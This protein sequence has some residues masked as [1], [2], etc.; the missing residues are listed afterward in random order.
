M[1]LVEEYTCI[2]KETDVEF[3][4]SYR[5]IKKDYN[6]VPAYGIEIERKDYIDLKN[7]GLERERIE[8]ISPQRHKVK[9]LLMKLY[10]NQVSP[11]H[12]MDVIG[13]YV[14]E[15]VYEFDSDLQRQ[16]IN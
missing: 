5:L 13:S 3:R 16:A 2:N 15:Y 12:L 8:I 4:Y 10:N 14:D 9:E 6:G 11:I 1:N 7:I